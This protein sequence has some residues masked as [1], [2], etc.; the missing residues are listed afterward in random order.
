MKN[1]SRKGQHLLACV[2]MSSGGVRV[3]G[4]VKMDERMTDTATHKK[5]K[6]CLRRG[7]GNAEI[8]IKSGSERLLH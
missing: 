4:M 6:S 8:H 5:S 3:A 1:G 2:Y 7:R